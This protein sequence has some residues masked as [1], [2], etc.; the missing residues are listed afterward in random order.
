M[1]HYG[2][3]VSRVDDPRRRVAERGAVVL[4]DRRRAGR[5][6]RRALVVWIVLFTAAV[7]W[8]GRSNRELAQD[9]RNAKVALC[10]LRRTRTAALNRALRY[11]RD[12][13]YG[14]PGLFTRAELDA[15]IREQ[16]QTRRA[17]LGLDCQKGKR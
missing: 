13:P 1:D 12:H 16:R 7:V 14:V 4:R 6:A 3:L 17:L 8:L 10:E 5:Y 11:R 9:G 15:S 2:G